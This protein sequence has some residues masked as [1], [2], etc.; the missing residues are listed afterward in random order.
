M[1]EDKDIIPVEVPKTVT[2]VDYG[3]AILVGLFFIGS[4]FLTQ[5]ES[6]STP[7]W[8]ATSALIG[9]LV[10]KQVPNRA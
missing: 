3:L 4:C 9:V 10:G 6:D 1:P 8:A 5:Q 2:A 7:A